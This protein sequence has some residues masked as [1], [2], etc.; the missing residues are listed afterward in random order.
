[1]IVGARSEDEVGGTEDIKV[2]K[3]CD[4]YMESGESRAAGD[5]DKIGNIASLSI[6]TALY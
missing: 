6:Y 3:V 1:M 2:I 4:E 5:H